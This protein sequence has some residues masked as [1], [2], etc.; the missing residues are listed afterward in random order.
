M[1]EIN[2]KT[3]KSA[4]IYLS[5]SLTDKTKEIVVIF[6]GYAQLAKYFI[7]KFDGI[8]NH[9]R[10]VIAPEGLS[11]FYWNGMNGR[12]VA[13]WMTKEDRLSEIEDQKMY[14]DRVMALIREKNPSA[15][16]TLLGF[17]QGCATLARW[18]AT[19]HYE[20]NRTIFWAGFIPEDVMEL[21][22]F[23]ENNI[24]FIIGKNDEFIL[25]ENREKTIHLMEKMGIN[26]EVILFDG[27]HTI[28][29]NI[30]LQVF[31]KNIS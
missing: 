7:K 3:E 2:I 6:H 29:E 20:V 1:N 31:D 28:P 5:N 22:F 9:E 15:K 4:R 12:V 14:L 24:E 8:Q 17:S 27:D 11:K 19:S 13:S 16:L 30:L 18:I 26:H 10:I 21:E 23:K 25:D